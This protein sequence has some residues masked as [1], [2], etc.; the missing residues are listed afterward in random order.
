MRKF[1]LHLGV[2]VLS[3]AL[4]AGAWADGPKAKAADKP[5][6]SGTCGDYGTSVH[7]EKSPSEAARKAIKEQKLVFVLHISGYF[8]DSDFT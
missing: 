2:G 7:F 5:S 6:D 1:I 4:V 8:E 3:L